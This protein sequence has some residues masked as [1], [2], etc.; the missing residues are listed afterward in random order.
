MSI[1]LRTI[2]G[3]LGVIVIIVGVAFIIAAV[4]SPIAL[5]FAGRTSELSIRLPRISAGLLAGIVM[6][7]IGFW[8]VGQAM[9]SLDIDITFK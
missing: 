7:G 5:L 4:Q 6:I 9:E 1:D 3:W 8:G 2:T